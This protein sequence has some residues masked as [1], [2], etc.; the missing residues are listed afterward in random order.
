[1]PVHETRW[2]FKDHERDNHGLCMRH[3]RQSIYSTMQSQRKGRGGV[4]AALTALLSAMTI[5]S[6]SKNVAFS[7]RVDLLLNLTEV[8][9]RN[10]TQVFTMKKVYVSFSVLLWHKF[11]GTTAQSP[12]TESPPIS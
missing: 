3:S 1:M 6:A 4:F 10:P 12:A 8:K 11:G 7:S 2:R 9:Q 5:E